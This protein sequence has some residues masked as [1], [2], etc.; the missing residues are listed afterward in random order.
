MM[1]SVTAIATA[2]KVMVRV[3]LKR[4]IAVVITAEVTEA[5]VV[6]TG[7]IM[8]VAAAVAVAAKEG[9]SLAAIVGIAGLT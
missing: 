8:V 2:A 9:E 3:T 6:R 4:A 5:L 1:S 7:M